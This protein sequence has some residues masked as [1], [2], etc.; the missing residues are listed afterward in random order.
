LLTLIAARR[1][2]EIEDEA[3]TPE[4]TGHAERLIADGLER[5]RLVPETPVAKLLAKRGAAGIDEVEGWQQIIAMDES[6]LVRAIRAVEE[7]TA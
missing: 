7:G 1:A 2:H 5:V 6:A 4:N 3:N